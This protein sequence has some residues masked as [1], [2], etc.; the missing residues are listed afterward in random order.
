[1]S[2][3]RKILVIG[4]G[5]SGITAAVEAAEVGYEVILVEKEPYLGGRVARMHKYFPKM[6][7]PT[8][9]LEINFRRIRN[10]PRIQVHTM[11]EVTRISGEAGN[12]DVQIRLRPRYVNN[13]ARIPD[14]LVDQVKSEMPDEF[15][16]G[17][18]KTKALYYPHPMAFPMLHVLEKDA[19][20]AEDRALLEKETPKGI[21][22]FNMAV[23][24]ISEKV[25][26]IVVATGWRPYDAQK[27]DNLG[28]GRCENVITNVMM[29]R[30]VADSGPTQGKLKRMS[31]NEEIKKVAFV[32]CAG[33]RDEN[34]LPY[35][36]GVCCMGSLKQ[37]RY[38]REKLPDAHITIFYIDI[39]AIS[40]HEKFYYDL[41]NDDHI[42][43]VKGKAAMITE[44]AV[45]R[46]AVVEVENTLSGKKMREP[47][48]LVVLA[49]GMVPNTAKTKI[50]M[51]SLRYDEYGFV[52]PWNGQKGVYA[53]GCALRPVD[54]ARSVR[55]ATGAAI[56]A[57]QCCKEV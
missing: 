13:G 18:N 45:S 27:I 20:S 46:D 49:T 29:E 9:G 7:P 37:A 28:F 14:S 40:R 23:Q 52:K 43:F 50:P 22:D 5:I 34:H 31:D 51:D 32:Q 1:M 25:G 35:C 39:R 24:E 41:L 55:Q 10:N 8:C 12:F 56:K 21:I 11:A 47:F 44:D 19:L 16:L 48:D 3:K 42:T 4:G 26:A 6:C 2:E 54:V 33:S 17:M 53:V 36:S 38:V 30:L 15:N 57:I